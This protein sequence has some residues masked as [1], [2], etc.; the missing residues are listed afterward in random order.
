MRQKKFG[1]LIQSNRLYTIFKPSQKKHPSS[2]PDISK[3]PDRD[4]QEQR[5]SCSPIGTKQN[6]WLL[7]CYRDTSTSL[8]LEH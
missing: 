2:F 4:S 5:H 8:F 1:E 3:Q 7:F 6:R